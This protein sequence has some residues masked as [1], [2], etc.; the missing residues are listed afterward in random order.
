M[1]IYLDNRPVPWAGEL[2]PVEAIA[3]LL[4]DVNRK[5]RVVASIV[6]DGHPLGS[7]WEEVY[8]RIGL[9]EAR[10]LRLRTMPARQMLWETLIVLVQEL[11]SLLDEIEDVARRLQRGEDNESFG[12]LPS[13]LEKVESYTQFLGALMQHEPAQVAT[14]EQHISQLTHWMGQVMEAWRRED[15][16]L[17]AD[18]L[19]YEL[20]P[21]FRAG[22]AWMQELARQKVP[23]FQATF[24]QPIVTTRQN[25][26]N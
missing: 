6:L 24:H 7:A 4:E 5:G 14:A 25:G 21:I 18:Y 20:A 23:S 9:G 22:V 19:E 15:F 1:D 3:R 26:D 16:V 10:Q 13:L 2:P 12:K 17:V 8:R 11:P